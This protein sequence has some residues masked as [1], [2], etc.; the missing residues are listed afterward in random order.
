MEMMDKCPEYQLLIPCQCKERKSGL[1]ITC[2]NVATSQ[3]EA[4]TERMKQYKKR[5][6]FTVSVNSVLHIFYFYILLVLYSFKHSQRLFS[7]YAPFENCEYKTEH[8]GAI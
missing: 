3:L 1:D 7:M 8:E 4:V 2:E 6:D 5:Q